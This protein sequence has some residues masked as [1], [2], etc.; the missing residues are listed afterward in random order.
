[1]HQGPGPRPP[2][3]PG[4]AAPW[5]SVRL[6]QRPGRRAPPRPPVEH[7]LP[8][9]RPHPPRRTPAWSREPDRDPGSHGVS[10]AR[11]PRSKRATIHPRSRPRRMGASA[12]MPQ[13]PPGHP[14]GRTRPR[15]LPG[16]GP[17]RRVPP[18]RA[19]RSLHCSS[20]LVRVPGPRD[21][22]GVPELVLGPRPSQCPDR[23]PPIRLAGPRPCCLLVDRAPP[24]RWCSERPARAR[25]ASMALPSSE[26]NR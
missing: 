4:R 16:T 12:A 19:Q 25:P 9:A 6:R 22:D 8:R 15:L 24:I 5:P 18:P 3:P 26:G 11:G 7:P 14:S 21:G 20:V 1:M 10:A 23:P 13:R 17:L 2:R